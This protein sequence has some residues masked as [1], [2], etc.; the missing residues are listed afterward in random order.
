VYKKGFLGVSKIAVV[1][2]NAWIIAGDI[3]GKVELFIKAQDETGLESES[4]DLVVIV[5]EKK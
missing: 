5:L 3:K 1:Q 2:E 4:S